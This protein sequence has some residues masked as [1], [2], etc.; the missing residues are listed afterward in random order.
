MKDAKAVAT[1]IGTVGWEAVMHRIPVIMFGLF[2]YENM[3]G[4]MRVTDSKSAENIMSF[5]ESYKYDEHKVLAYLM[6][7]ADN[8]VKAYHYDEEKEISDVS[9]DES[10]QN[11]KKMILSF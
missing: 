9:E 7:V 1:V 4:V 6:S 8:T 2:W 11:I 3:P 10:I 5:I